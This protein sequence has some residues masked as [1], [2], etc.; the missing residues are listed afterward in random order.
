MRSGKASAYSHATPLFPGKQGRKLAED[1]MD[2]KPEKEP[3]EEPELDPA[4]VKHLEARLLAMLK[5][6]RASGQ[7]KADLKKLLEIG[8]ELGRRHSR[9]VQAQH[10][11]TYH[12]LDCVHRVL[13][14]T[15]VDDNPELQRQ[16]VR[17][18]A[19]RAPGTVPA[20]IADL[21]ERMYGE[22]PERSRLR[23]WTYSLCEAIRN[24]CKPGEV[25]AF[26]KERKLRN[27]YADFLEW[28]RA[29]LSK[30][31]GE[32]DAE[33][34]GGRSKT[35]ADPLQAGSKPKGTATSRSGPPPS[36]GTSKKAPAADGRATADRLMREV[37]ARRAEVVRGDESCL[38]A[39][40]ERYRNGE[41][42]EV[43]LVEFPQGGKR[44]TRPDRRPAAGRRRSGPSVATNAGAGKRRKARSAS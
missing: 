34:G 37:A 13:I 25:H 7:P 1:T 9:A 12:F 10:E 40:C 39:V 3:R 16:L 8:A 43:K 27:V 21:I 4:L 38:L 17:P 30:A 31:A 42:I 44:A 33:S 36:A 18:G 32:T 41:L 24:D 6:S 28:K 11:L 35:G 20:I 26:F 29:A 2:T 14:R 5:W 22:K 19:R 15:S 23:E